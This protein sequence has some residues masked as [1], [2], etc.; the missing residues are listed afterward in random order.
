MLF[1]AVC[2]SAWGTEYS[3]TPLVSLDFSSSLPTVS[4]VTYN[5]AS[6]SSGKISWSGNYS[7]G[8]RDIQIT[9]TTTGS[10]FKVVIGHVTSSSSMTFKYA[11]D[12]GSAQNVT[13]TKTGTSDNVEISATKGSHTI[14]LGPG[15]SSTRAVVTSIA[16]YDEAGSGGDVTTPVLPTLTDQTVCPGSDIAP[17]D[18]TQTA[19]LAEGESVA[20]EWKKQGS[21]TVLA[22]TATL[23]LGSSA[24]AEMAGTYVVTATVSKTGYTSKSAS[25]EVTLTVSTIEE[26]SISAN[27]AAVY[28][29]NSVTLTASCATAGVTWKWY[30]CTN[31]A[32]DGE[33]EIG[34]ATSEEYTIASAGS[35]GVYYY[36]AKATLVSCGSAEHVYTLTVT[37]ADECTKE[38]WFAKEADRPSGAAE[39]THITNTPSGSSSVSYTAS[40]EGTDYTI[41]GSTGQKTGNITIEVPEDNLG[42]LY[43]VVAGSSSRTI[44]LSKGETEI[45]QQTPAN[46]T[47]GVYTFSGLEAGT[48]KL[49]SSGNINWGILALKLCPTITCSDAL[50]A[51]SATNDTIC[52]GGTTTLSATGYEVGATLQWQK[53]NS[54]SGA[55]EDISGATNATY[56]ISSAAA[57]H[58]GNYHVVATKTC[59]RTSGTLAIAVPA[60]P[61]FNSF[62]T[63][64][65][66]ME[67][68]T[69]YIS[70]VSATDAVSYAW[71]KSADATWDAG[72]TEIGT[73]K[74]LAKPSA[75]EIAN[76]TYYVFCRAT[77][78][79]GTTTSDAIEITV[80]TYV[81]EDCAVAGSSG[82]HNTYYQKDGSAGTFGSVT[83]VHINSNNK[84]IY[85]VA[86]SGYYFATATV[87]VAVASQTKL[88]TAAYSYST[89]GGSSWEDQALPDMTET[90]E[91]HEIE[92]PSNVNAF[93]IG[94][95][96]GDFGTGSS[97]IYIHQVCFTYN[98]DCKKTDVEPSVETVDYII[99]DDFTEPTFTVMHGTTAF[100]PQPTITY[101]SSDET[102]ATVDEDGKL[103]FKDK[104]GT[105]VI[106]ASYA[107][108]ATYCASEGSYTISI[109][110]GDEAPKIVAAAGTNI[111]GCNSSITLLM[112]KQ[113]GTSDFADGSYQWYRDGSAIEGAT[114]MSYVVNE[115]GVYTVERTNLSGCI[116][117]SSNKVTVTSDSGDPVVERLTPFQYYHAGKTYTE[118]MKMRHLFAVKNSGT[119]AA[120]KPF[121]MKL[122][123]NGGAA[124]DVTSE[125]MFV[126]NADTVLLD[127][128][129]MSGKGYN[130]GD[131]LELTCSAIECSGAVSATYTNTITI[132]VIDDKPTLALICSG[133]KSDGTGDFLTGYEPK[134]LLQQT[135]KS[136]YSGE[137]SMY[138]KLK[139][140]YNVTPVNGYA[141]FNKLNYEPFDILFLT[142]FPKASTNATT[143]TILDDM[144]DLCDYRPLFTFK[145]HMVAKSPSK[146]AAKGFKAEPTVPATC[147]LRLNIVCYAHPMFAELKTDPDLSMM[148]DA[149]DPSQIVYEMLSGEGYETRDFKPHPDGGNKTI[150]KGIQGFPIDAAEG[151]V[152]IGL[153]HFNATAADNTPST[154]Y[155]TWTP[156]NSD[157]L[158]VAAAERQ[159]NPEARMIL[160]SLNAGAHSKLNP[161]G[162]AIVMK[163]LEYLLTDA[164]TTMAECTITFTNGEGNS[165]SQSQYEAACPACTGE[166]G[167]GKWSTAA[168]W[169]PDY[170]LVPGESTDVKVKKP[171][172]VDIPNA[173]VRSIRLVE[174]GRVTIPAGKALEVTTTIRRLD[175]VLG[176]I[177]P[178]QEND[179]SIEASAD[180]S[181]TLILNNNAGDTRA[182]VQF[183]SKAFI[184]HT[185][186]AKEPKGVKNYQYIGSP[187]ASANALHNYYNSY[188]YSWNGSKWTAVPKAANMTPWTGY[189][190]TQENATVYDMSGTLEQTNSID[191]SVPAG[192]DMVV[193]NSWTAPIDI[194]A[195]QD[196]D[197]ENLHKNIY[198]FN[199]GVDKAHVYA[200]A[201]T[202]YEA[203][204][205]ITVPI[206]AGTYTGDDR[207][208]S[209]QGFFVTSGGSAGKLH[210]D[211]ERHVRKTTRPDILSGELHAPS[212][213]MAS[214]NSEPEVMKIKVSGENYDDLLVLLAREDFTNGL[215]E[216]WDGDKWDGNAAS[217]FL[218]T[219]DNRGVENSVSAVP[220]LEGTIVG[221]RA[222]EDEEYTMHFECLNTEEMFYLF[223]METGTY[224]PIAAGNTYRFM[225]SDK[226]KH[227]RFFITRTNPQIT[228]ET[229]ELESSEK[230][231]VHKLLI[232]NQIYIL[233]SGELYD[234]T[235]KKVHCTNRKEAAQ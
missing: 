235:G 39:A 6:Y 11:L 31:A 63:S 172:T 41:S 200:A 73:E 221:F 174:N 206:H 216:G 179:L 148:K 90:Y 195:L 78:S 50:P 196:E 83:E 147:A 55:W 222:G 43:V 178:T 19:S 52:V 67:T 138:T 156:G 34:G 76:S 144:A 166:K 176:A 97:T 142:D 128:N 213:R 126:M 93:R 109:S 68:Q 60:E 2:I 132:H 153:I 182:K 7:K 211:Y 140:V 180:S 100:D 33:S 171:V 1:A 117:P 81:S 4:G 220:E 186:P 158:L 161:T 58:A 32:G 14:S 139:T 209:Q 56:E 170:I 230:G 129:K 205:Y 194:N 85:Y 36:K 26:P 151:F 123:K 131:E 27:K 137:W 23:D 122:S 184:D 143:Q 199:T 146:W 22:S 15:G 168:N 46:S 175:E 64:R 88:P 37:A 229:G 145:T 233:R 190:I 9:F 53:Q 185:D 155:V 95:R 21:E 96:L 13:L 77:N 234:L 79:C 232:E 134:N 188:L 49:V 111:G 210:L 38:F 135:G 187:F 108:D 20:Y 103:D 48:Y 74:N 119:S 18:A 159:V 124:T 207:I 45:G 57:E 101:T 91:D 149:G 84:Y 51:I 98:E 177:L 223:D 217:M 61:V 208:P 160:F 107:G 75:G 231:K 197:F 193:G 30:T 167:D 3:S 5:G 215:D 54:T 105:L 8:S 165:M 44:T 118:Q 162:E 28:P 104:A 198:F 191:I 102:I 152:T 130:A 112:K 189:C 62:S 59:S 169:G 89:D 66:V 202:R 17:W 136:S 40:I 114:G 29:G 24:T 150:K 164:A 65:R 69:L 92:F 141:N 87:N 226:E 163:S 70:D 72:D 133:V 110:C 99:G 218:Y 115:V 219:L 173:K 157:N 227:E 82:V 224:V 12:A 86:E 228:T 113:D 106:T 47:W 35:V 214:A 116:S 121:D 94:R 10:S 80:Q 183:Y 201:S 225:T 204:K 42:T 120:G 16:I 127:L 154:G 25:Q 181:G 203:G 192:A 212:R 125:D 71:Y